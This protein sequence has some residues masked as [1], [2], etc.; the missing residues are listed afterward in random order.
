MKKKYLFFTLISIFCMAANYA[1]PVTPTYFK[2]LNLSNSMFGIAFAV[3]SLGMFISSPFWGKMTSLINSK[4]AMAIGSIGYGIAQ[5][6]FAFGHTVPIIIAGRL[7]AGLACGAFFV[8]TLTYI[9]NVTPPQERGAALT[10]NAT[11]QTV[12]SALGYFVGGILGQYSLNAAFALQVV[13]LI[14]VGIAYYLF[15]EK[16]LTTPQATFKEIIH[17][18]NP[19]KAFL[20]G[21]K[22][23]NRSFSA[24]FILSTFVFLGYTAFDQSFN[25]YLKDMIHLSSA[26]NGIFKGIVGLVSLVANLTICIYLLKKTN[27]KKSILVVLGLS[28]AVM[29]ITIFIKPLPL[30]LTLNFV[31]YGGY[32]ITVPLIQDLITNEAS[33][34]NRNMVL[35]FYQATQ[36]LGMIIGAFLAGEMY[37]MQPQSPF[38]LGALAFVIALGSG[39]VYLKSSR[40]PKLNSDMIKET[41]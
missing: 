6:M 17:E 38:V 12:T 19:L 4:S 1:H 13:Q 37:K 29:L 18:S 21:K 33:D 2:M 39:W 26:Y 9:A 10:W 22:F 5:I 24:L 34:K 16:D 27:I 28:A 11:I 20:D 25:Y 35:G 31:F 30:Y 41:N 15:L 36:S 40:Q 7:L 8:G 32:A 23:M 3:M 14:L